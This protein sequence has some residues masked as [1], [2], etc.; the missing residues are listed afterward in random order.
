MTGI[1]P[2]NRLNYASCRLGY[3]FVSFL[4]RVSIS[5]PNGGHRIYSAKNANPL[6]FSYLLSI[7]NA[8]KLQMSIIF[9]T[10]VG[11]KGHSLI[12]KIMTKF[13]NNDPEFG[14][15]SAN[16]DRMAKSQGI[17]ELTNGFNEAAVYDNSPLD[18]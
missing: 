10:F 6:I 7:F 2:D 5:S 18:F 16:F 3:L 1:M 8:I 15:I 4:R 11:Y 9:R 14:Y 13:I 12:V 17:Y